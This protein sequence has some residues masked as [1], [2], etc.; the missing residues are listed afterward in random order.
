MNQRKN[1]VMC[2]DQAVQAVDHSIQA[3]ITEFRRII[4][5]PKVIEHDD[6]FLIESDT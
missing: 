3:Q 4:I 6:M 1:A 2:R 5:D